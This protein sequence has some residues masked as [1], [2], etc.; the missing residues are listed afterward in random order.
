MIHWRESA[1]L[2]ADAV[3]PREACG[4]VVRIAG[5]EVYWPCQNIAPSDDAF[6]A[7]PLD[8]TAAEDHGEV[9]AVVHSHPGQQV[10]R[11]GPADMR[12][13]DAGSI[14]WHV[15]GWPS[16]RWVTCEP[17]HRIPPLEGREF[18]HGVT[19]CYSIIRDWYRLQGTVLPDYP[20]A[21]G[22][23]DQGLSLYLDQ[24]ADAGFVERDGPPEPGDVLLMQVGA[25]VPNHAAIYL[26]GDRILHHLAG[27]LSRAEPWSSDWR[28][29]TVK[30][31]RYA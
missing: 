4:L 3:A 15:I 5:D 28:K 29:R 6:Q 2:H 22:W 17:V 27:R 11:P 16:A 8:L 18:V 13:C 31:L 25:R 23:W 24:F 9:L 7:D 20:R 14:P 1:A 19:D 21:D 30:V 26:P 10:P 12:A